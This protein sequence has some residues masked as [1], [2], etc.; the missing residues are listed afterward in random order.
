MV[1]CLRLH[2]AFSA[3]RRVEEL[4]LLSSKPVTYMIRLSFNIRL[5]ILISMGLPTKM[6]FFLERSV[7]KRSRSEGALQFTR[8]GSLVNWKLFLLFASC[9]GHD[10]LQ[11]RNCGKY[12]ETPR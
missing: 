2:V 6:F 10:V 3:S 9:G 12:W 8:F 5:R 7:D 11:L 4:R 1:G